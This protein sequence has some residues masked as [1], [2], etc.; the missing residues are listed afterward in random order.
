MSKIPEDIDKTA[1]DI[2]RAS[3]PEDQDPE[4]FLYEAIALALVAERQAQRDRVFKMLSGIADLLAKRMV[5]S[6]TPELLKALA[7]A[8]NSS[9]EPEAAA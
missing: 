9:D 4:W 6:A 3:C 7:E 2:V 1:T 5:D 8:V